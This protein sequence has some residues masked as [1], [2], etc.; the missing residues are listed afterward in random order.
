MN[1]LNRKRMDLIHG[2]SGAREVENNDDKDV[3]YRIMRFLR[4]KLGTGFNTLID[5]R[6]TFLGPVSVF[7]DLEK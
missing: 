3:R 6:Q 1:A 5:I 4:K 2:K 7:Y